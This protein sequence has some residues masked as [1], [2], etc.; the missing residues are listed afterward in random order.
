MRPSGRGGQPGHVDVD[1]HDPVD[2][3]DRRVAPLVAAARA[4]AVAH[5]D[6][7]LGLR[8]L[9][10]EA[11]QRAGHLGRQRAGDDQHVGLARAGPER[12]H[13]PA[14]HVVLRRRGR[15]HLDRAAGQAGQQRPQAVHPDQ[16]EDVVGLGRDDLEDAAPARVVA[17]PEPA[18]L[19]LAQVGRCRSGGRRR[20]PPGRPPARA[21]SGRR[22][23]RSGRST[24]RSPRAGCSRSSPEPAPFAFG[25]ASPPRQGSLPPG[26]GEAEEQDHDE[27]EHAHQAAE[28]QVVEGDRPEVDEDT[29]MSKATKSRA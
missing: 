2:P 5:R 10:P 14:V 17:A 20:R 25:R 16:V 24:R 21:C 11:D 9:L 22:S 26:V 3:L 29:S 4:G 23:G 28:Q 13:A 1:R 18:R 7:P 15:H 8:H 27:D 12:E 6:A 19:E